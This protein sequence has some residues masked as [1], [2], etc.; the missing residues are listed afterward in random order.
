MV[1]I[2]SVLRV[3]NAA[4]CL[5][6]SLA[7][8]PVINA[9]DGGK[10]VSRAFNLY[11]MEREMALGKQLAAELERQVKLANEPIL[12]EYLNRVAQNLSRQ[13]E[14]AIPVSVRLIESG[15]LNAF[16][17]PGGHVYITSGM[18]RLTESE[19]ELAFVL[20]HELG[21]VAARHATR[22]ASRGDLVNL[23]SIPLGII[24]GWSGLALRQMAGPGSRLGLVKGARDFELQADRLGM[25]FLEAASYDSTAAIDVF[26]R[27]ESTE[28]RTSGK[29]ARL[30]A[31]HPLTAERI[32]RAQRHLK[33]AVSQRPEHIINTSEYETMRVRAVALEEK[34]IREAAGTAR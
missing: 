33:E 34:R 24:G 16:T 27:I 2:C 32:E 11:S 1:I 25:D 26:E 14:I 6:L 30:A 7:L 29:L 12:S 17:L 10:D 9:R 15:D 5:V 20:A 28:R 19:A 13:S 3:C 31:G 4:V 23:G 18:L 8:A 21:H 22:E